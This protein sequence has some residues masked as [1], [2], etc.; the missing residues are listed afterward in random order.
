MKH[1]D[2][3]YTVAVGFTTGFPIIPDE[4]TCWV[5][6]SAATDADARLAA[7]QMVYASSRPCLMCTSATILACLA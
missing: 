6:V 4:V 7:C 3:T 2:L 5:L 1:P